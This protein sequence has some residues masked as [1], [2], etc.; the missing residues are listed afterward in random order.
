MTKNGLIYLFTIMMLAGC[1]A[2]GQE[3][4]D[5]LSLMQTTNPAPRTLEKDS[6]SASAESIKKTVEKYPDIYDVA[7]IKGEKEDLVVYK[8]KQMKRFRMKKIEKE[9]TALLE[10]KFPEGEFIVSSDYKI[11]LEAVRLS[12]KMKD[13]SFSRKKA[14]KRLDEIITLRNELT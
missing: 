10:K 5:Y 9:V 12:E 8:V 1:G 2:N 11:F 13:P 4:Q 6:N 7:V 14:Q 3:K